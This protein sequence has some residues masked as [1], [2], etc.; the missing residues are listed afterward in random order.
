[1]HCGQVPECKA[2]NFFCCL[3]ASSGTGKNETAWVNFVL[4]RHNSVWGSLYIK[5][6]EQ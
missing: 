1:M 5:E 2:Y 3:S 4:A 6:W